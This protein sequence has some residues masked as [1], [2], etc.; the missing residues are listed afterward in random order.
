M[1]TKGKVLCDMYIKLLVCTVKDV[2]K[3]RMVERLYSR[4]CLANTLKGTP[5]LYFLSELLIIS[6]G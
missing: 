2:I 5:N 3:V 1:L 4:T 6:T